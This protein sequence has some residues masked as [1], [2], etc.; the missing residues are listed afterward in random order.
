MTK[1]VCG[2]ERVGYSGQ[3]SER[4][5]ISGYDDDIRRYISRYDGYE[6]CDKSVDDGR[7]GSRSKDTRHSSSRNIVETVDVDWRCGYRS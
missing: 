5:D 7:L 6:R 4:G 1:T 3:G 2:D